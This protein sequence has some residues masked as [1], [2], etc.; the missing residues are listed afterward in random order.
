MAGIQDSLARL[1]EAVLAANSQALERERLRLADISRIQ[2]AFFALLEAYLADAPPVVSPPG[3]PP[4]ITAAGAT[5]T[6]TAALIS[7]A[8]TVPV[9]PTEPSRDGLDFSSD[10]L[11]F[12]SDV[13]RWATT[14]LAVNASLAS[15]RP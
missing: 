2:E 14:I 11:K 1:K 10:K 9:K 7:G 3:K 5:L 15:E 13:I 4:V 8:V 12:S 6:Q